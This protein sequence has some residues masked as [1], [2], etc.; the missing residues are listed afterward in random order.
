MLHEKHVVAIWHLGYHL[1]ICSWTQ[2]NQ[3]KPASRW[4]VAGLSGPCP[5]D[6]S[7]VTNVIKSH[8][9]HTHNTI[10]LKITTIH[11]IT[12]MHMENYN[13]SHGKLQQCTWKMNSN[14]P[15]YC[16]RLLTL[17]DKQIW[18]PLRRIC[19]P[20]DEFE[21]HETNLNTTSRIWIPRYGFEYHE[22]YIYIQ[23]TLKSHSAALL[24]YCTTTLLHL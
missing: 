15:Q 18:I 22:T 5:L 23:G 14:Y 8:M 13:N 7:A 2:E 4:P 19:P 9:A 11:T 20:R 17:N 6:S 3:E 24:H 21:C 12:T 1:S 10:T 16:L